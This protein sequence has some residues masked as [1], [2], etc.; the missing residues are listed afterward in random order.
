MW[1]VDNRLSLHVG[2]TECLLFGSGGKLKRV[3]E[4]RVTCDGLPVQRDY[5]VKYL[6][7]LLD[8]KFNGSTHVGTL[9]KTCSAR[10]AFLFR[11]SSLLDFQCRKT[12]CSALIQP[13]VDYCSS[14][15]YSCLL[16]ALR[17]CLDVLQRKMAR[18]VFGYDNRRHI[19][20]KE[21]HSLL[22]LSV[23]D[24]AIG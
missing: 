6:G 9:L 2:K 11:N 17:S 4:F 15:W 22:W 10:L 14:S 21:F 3:G 23:P 8:E 12:L 5:N 19:G 24:T 20:M 1:L 7:V 13:H 16:A 18:F